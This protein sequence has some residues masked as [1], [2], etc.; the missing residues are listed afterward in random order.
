MCLAIP[1]RIEK[2]LGN[3]RALAHLGGVSREI[4]TCLLDDV[5]VGDYVI[6]HVGFALTKLNEVEAQKTLA[7]L[8]TLT[9]NN[10]SNKKEES[11]YAL[12]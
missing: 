11:L 3:N 8:H 4:S 2:I 1:A 12:S 7:L 5:V 9:T 6:L 10:K